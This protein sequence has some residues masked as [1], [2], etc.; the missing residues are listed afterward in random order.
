MIT[1]PT[2]QLPL[3]MK[4]LFRSWYLS[5][6]SLYSAARD[7]PSV[8][9]KAYLQAN[10]LVAQLRESDELSDLSKNPLLLNIEENLSEFGW[11]KRV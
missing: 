11:Y 2:G 3:K 8:K 9:H 10:R 7:N 1:L 6:E 4:S 5:Q